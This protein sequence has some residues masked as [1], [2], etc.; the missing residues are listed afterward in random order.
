MLCES[1]EDHCW[2]PVHG[3]HGHVIFVEDVERGVSLRDHQ[4]FVANPAQSRRRFK[5]LLRQAAEI[6]QKRATERKQSDPV[7]NGILQSV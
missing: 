7:A 6:Q 2:T 1:R 5:S 4:I 3:L